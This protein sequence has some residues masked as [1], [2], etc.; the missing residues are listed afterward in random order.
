MS[1]SKNLQIGYRTGTVVQI[2]RK[3]MA[4]NIK[5][6]LKEAVKVVTATPWLRCG[7]PPIRKNGEREM[8]R[9][10]NQIAKGII[11]ISR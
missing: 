5:L 9:R 3:L 1:I 10:R 7:H 2:A 11:R 6:T 8:A 4:D